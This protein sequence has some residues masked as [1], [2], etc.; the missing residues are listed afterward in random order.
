[1][2]QDQS[3]RQAVKLNNQQ[4]GRTGEHFVAAEL[5]RRDAYAVTFSGNMPDID[6]LASDVS[7]ARTVS[8]QVKTKTTGTWQ[9]S[10]RRGRPREENP[11]E[12]EFWIFVDVGRNPEIRP[13]Y[14]VVPSWW[15]ENSIHVEHQAY[16]AR[17]SG[18]R[19][20]SPQSTHHAV[21]LSR[22]EQWRE[23]WDVLG[24]F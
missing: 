23:R 16:I 3:P 10:T 21:P 14:F 5:H 7:R 12:T 1:M 8:I 15:I 17:H 2:P 9:T 11:Y 6:I 4:V 18:Q 13:H 24:I 19:A 20:R 22:V